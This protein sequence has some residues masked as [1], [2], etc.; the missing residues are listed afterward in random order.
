MTTDE[1]LS[2]A[3]WGG[4]DHRALKMEERGPEP[5]MQVAARS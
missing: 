2:D 4:L 3:L 5:R 1:G